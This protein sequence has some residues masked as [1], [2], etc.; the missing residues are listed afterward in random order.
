[1]DRNVFKRVE[2]CFPISDQGMKKRLLS[3]LDLCVQ[4]NT[5]AWELQADG[6]WRRLQP[7]AGEDPISIQGELLHTLSE[8][9]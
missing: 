7:N 9:G 2:V 1:M 8:W 4:D 6:S 5:G 3:D